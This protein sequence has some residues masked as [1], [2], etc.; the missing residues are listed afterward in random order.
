M[1]VI[2]SYGL[3]LGNWATQIVFD[4]KRK[5]VSGYGIAR[6]GHGKFGVNIG[7]HSII[8]LFL[9]RERRVVQVAL[10]E[11]RPARETLRKHAGLSHFIFYFN[12]IMIMSFVFKPYFKEI[13]S[14]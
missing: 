2:Y 4:G 14:S 9:F 7:E 12:D 10:V 13:S 6:L 5:S 3:G 8:N 1:C 11:R